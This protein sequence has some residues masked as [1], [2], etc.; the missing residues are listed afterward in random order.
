MDGNPTPY[1]YSQLDHGGNFFRVARLKAA[2]ERGAEIDCDLVDAQIGDG[3]DYEAVSYTWGTDKDADF[4][5]INEERLGIGLNLSLILRDLRLVNEDRVLWI[6]AICIDQGNIPERSHQVQRMGD[7]FRFARQVLFCV[8]RPTEMTDLLFAVL[9]ELHTC[10]VDGDH[11]PTDSRSTAEAR[12]TDVLRILQKRHYALM[13]R[14]QQGFDIIFQQSWFYRVWIVQEVANAGQGRIHCGSPSL[15]TDVFLAGLR[16]FNVTPP[17]HCQQILDMLPGQNRTADRQ[18]LFSLL[19]RLAASQASDARDKVWALLDL[20]SDLEAKTALKPDYGKSEALLVLDMITYFCG[21]ETTL[22]APRAWTEL[23]QFLP[24]IENLY[25]TVLEWVIAADDTVNLE[26]LLASDG[27]KGT[28]DLRVLYS[29]IENP[30]SSG[31]LI[32]SSAGCWSSEQTQ[33][34]AGP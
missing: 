3:T 7:I 10:L 24:C 15:A 25:N 12:S 11:E 2:K 23:S 20:C 26:V 33:N 5:V 28:I 8:G 13:P 29:A 27:D 30:K 19:Q 32:M 9:R 18:P 31:R 22:I 6:D 17:P 4:V 14:V 16:F 1:K 21:C 34:A